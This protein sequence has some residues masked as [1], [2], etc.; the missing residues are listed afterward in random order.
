MRVTFKSGYSS[1][2][3]DMRPV[4]RVVREVAAKI[5]QVLLLFR[6]ITDPASILPGN[7]AAVFVP[8]T[9]FGSSKLYPRPD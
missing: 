7:V 5:V 4:N 3:N 8:R 2:N 9:V 6:Q 1:M